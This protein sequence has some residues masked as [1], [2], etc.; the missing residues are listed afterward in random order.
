MKTTTSEPIFFSVLFFY[1]FAKAFYITNLF[2]SIFQLFSLKLPYR[3]YCALPIM[4]II[5]YEWLQLSSYSYFQL[6]L[7]LSLEIPF[8]LI[9]NLPGVLFFGKLY[10]FCPLLLFIL[11]LITYIIILCRQKVLSQYVFCD[12]FIILFLVGI[13]ITVITVD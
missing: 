3:L 5:F 11:L 2:P 13:R 1:L 12:V 10:I 9:A 7:G 8:L 4:L 6:A